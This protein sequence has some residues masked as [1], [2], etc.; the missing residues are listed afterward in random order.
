MAEKAKQEGRNPITNRPTR[1]EKVDY[2]KLAAGK[3]MEEDQKSMRLGRSQKS[4]TISEVD[5]G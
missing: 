3:S 5:K 1:K 2:K 4:G